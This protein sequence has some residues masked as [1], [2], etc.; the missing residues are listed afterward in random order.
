L[1]A[2]DF[3][4]FLNNHRGRPERIDLRIV[5]D[6]PAGST[7]RELFVERLEQF[8]KNY[9]DEANLPYIQKSGI[10][11]HSPQQLLRDEVPAD[12]VQGGLDGFHSICFEVESDPASRRRPIG[13]VINNI[14]DRAVDDHLK[15]E[16]EY[17]Q[18]S[19]LV[20]LDSK[21]SGKR[22]RLLSDRN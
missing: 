12:L 4:D 15:W 14:R 13:I 21:S 16:K 5:P 1:P 3:A 10:R 2:G 8:V 19:P 20:L 11:W 7:M 9:L 18:R 6:A 17:R 22:L